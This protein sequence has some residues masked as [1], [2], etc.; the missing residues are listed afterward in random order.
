M[1]CVLELERLFGFRYF[2]PNFKNK[3]KYKEDWMWALVAVHDFCECDEFSSRFQHGIVVASAD[4]G[5]GE[6]YMFA[7]RYAHMRT[8]YL[9]TVYICIYRYIHTYNIYICILC[10]CSDIVT[11]L[12]FGANIAPKEVS[13]CWG[14]FLVLFFYQH[15]ETEIVIFFEVSKCLLQNFGKYVSKC[16]P[17]AIYII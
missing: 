17:V 15:L 4:T 9:I 6:D 10:V 5:F 16:R 2:L 3:T 1:K 11:D 8:W 12:H 7:C 14:H 13:K